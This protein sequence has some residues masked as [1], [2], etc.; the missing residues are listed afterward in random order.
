[1]C[2]NVEGEEALSLERKP[3]LEEGQG[4]PYLECAGTGVGGGGS[5]WD[6]GRS[7]SHTISSTCEH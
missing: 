5:S 2:Q 7:V 1:M 4:A 3:G 6:W